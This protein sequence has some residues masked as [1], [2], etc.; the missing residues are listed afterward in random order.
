MSD[1]NPLLE[2]IRNAA[3]DKKPTVD[4][5]KS[6]AGLDKKPT[7]AERDAAWDAYQA[8]QKSEAQADADDNALDAK[9]GYRIS[10]KQDGF[11]RAGR[12]WSG[13]T[14]IAADELS[15]EQLEQ[16]RSDPMFEVTL[17]LID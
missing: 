6:L 10:V 15:A 17:T 11:R 7:A 4:E 1:F 2:A 8:E 13:T 14:D 5:L 3:P 9:G 16:L 12:P